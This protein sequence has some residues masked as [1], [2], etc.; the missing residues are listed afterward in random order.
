MANLEVLALDPTA[1]QIEAPQT[2]NGYSMPRLVNIAP[3]AVTGTATTPSL[4]IAQAWSTTGAAT[5]LQVNVTSDTGPSVGSKLL[6]L[7]VGG[8]SKAYVTKTGIITANGY[9]G[10]DGNIGMAVNTFYIGP[11]GSGASWIWPIANNSTGGVSL[12]ALQSF[13]WSS[14]T[15]GIPPGDLAL[16]RD[17]ANTL[18]QRNGVNAQTSRIYNS[19]TDASNYSRLAINGNQIASEALGSGSLAV[20]VPTPLINMAQ[21][22]TAITVTGASGTGTTATLTFAAQTAAIPVGT[23]ITVAG[24]TPTG[25]NAT[26][27][28][29]TASSTT[30]VSYANATTGFTTG[31]T[32]ASAMTAL[33]VNVTDTSSDANSKLLDLQVG[34]V[35]KAN[36]D[37]TGVLRV[38]SNGTDPAVNVGG[39]LGITV[40]GSYVGFG[41]TGYSNFIA[42][43]PSGDLTIGRAVD[44]IVARDAAN[45]LAQRN[46]VNA[47]RFNLYNTYTSA[48]VYERVSL[49]AA[50]NVFYLGSNQTG[51][52]LRPLLISHGATAYAALPAAN[53]C[54]G[55]R[56]YVTDSVLAT[57]GAIVAGGGA[58]KTVVWS[59]GT[60]WLVG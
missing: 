23:L 8:V 16:Y 17:A 40:I 20:S 45:T 38:P 30:S 57:F 53:T 7:Q 44:L 41:N 39:S 3:E 24:M 55:S 6:D 11:V 56:A 47:Q 26:S 2:G 58:N 43:T 13:S 9:A 59:D 51:A 10:I 37:K 18:A 15:V 35:S 52:T 4:A 5:A 14:A 34:G 22:W 25:Y 50:S 48:S 27:V 31:G 21:T 19:Y 49:Y 1:P 54:E 36:I 60:N 33:K 46:G 32:V 29:V 12:T 28:A 42:M